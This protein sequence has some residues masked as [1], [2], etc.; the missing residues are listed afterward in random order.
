MWS[1]YSLRPGSEVRVPR[2][3]RIGSWKYSILEV[4]VMSWTGRIVCAGH[5][6]RTE[7]QVASIVIVVS[8]LSIYKCLASGASGR[9]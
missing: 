8:T 9:Q 6:L 4:F 5:P 1:V 3:Y 7:G 2:G